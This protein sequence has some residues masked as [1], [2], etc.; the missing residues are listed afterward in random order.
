ML[1]AQQDTARAAF[2]EHAKKKAPTQHQRI[3]A[4]IEQYGPCTGGEIAR[5]LKLAPGTVSARYAELMPKRLQWG[6]ERKCKVS[7]IK[8]LTIELAVQGRLC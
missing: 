3:I 5:A 4:H 6:I 8:C 2:H 1:I 7:G